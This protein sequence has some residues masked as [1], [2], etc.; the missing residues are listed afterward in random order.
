MVS[1]IDINVFKPH[2][3]TE[4][5]HLLE[6]YGDRSIII[7][8]GT[9]VITMLRRGKIKADHLIDISDL[10]ELRYVKIEQ[11]YLKI[12]S[13]VTLNEAAENHLIRA[14]APL[15]SESAR[16][17]GTWQVR[18]IA[19]VGGN[20]GRA[21]PA[22][23]LLLSLYPLEAD[24]LLISRSGS[25]VIPVEKLVTGPGVLNKRPDEL[26]AE[27]R[28]DIRNAHKYHFFKKIGSRV[29]NIIAVANLAG[30]L[31]DINKDTREV[32]GIR[33]AAGSVAPTPVRLRKTEEFLQHN[34]L[35][36][37]TIDEAIEIAMGEI[38]PITD[39]RA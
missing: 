30:I 20:I 15:I 19:T 16:N 7:A 24:V 28:I 39:L 3:L 32:A 6:E 4:A 1:I 27:I 29:T 17:M 5:L 10:D 23:D 26:I 35:S 36:S 13:L 21:S 22:G 9:D 8:G 12:G 37:R 33:I 31:W 34:E 11:G 14:W 38:K 2:S 18:N 25:R